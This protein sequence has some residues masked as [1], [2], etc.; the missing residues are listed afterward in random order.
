MISHSRYV[1]TGFAIGH[2]DVSPQRTI[3]LFLCSLFLLLFFLAASVKSSTLTYRLCRVNHSGLPQV[4]VTSGVNRKIL[5][6]LLVPHS[7]S[8]TDPTSRR[9]DFCAT[10][11]TILDTTVVPATV[12]RFAAEVRG[13]SSCSIVT[14]ARP[15]KHT[16]PPLYPKPLW[17]HRSRPD[18]SLMDPV[19]FK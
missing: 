10:P 15:I 3:Q 8:V 5:L 7:R 14:F 6:H 16:I 2:V 1:S 4:Q 19:F 9:H 13:P 17:W 11:K 18:T 12:Y